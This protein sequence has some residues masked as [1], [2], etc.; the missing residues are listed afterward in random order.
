MGIFLGS[1]PDFSFSILYHRG[2]W[3][4]AW[5]GILSQSR[6]R[7]SGDRPK[8]ALFIRLFPAMLSAMSI[9]RCSVFAKVSVSLSS[10]NGL[11]C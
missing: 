7:K 9:D 4:V 6:L 3:T 5:T 2:T 11:G 8:R 10:L 1:A